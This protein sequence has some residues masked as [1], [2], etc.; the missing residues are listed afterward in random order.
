MEACWLIKSL[1]MI[2]CT[3]FLYN[4]HLCYAEL[5]DA[6]LTLWMGCHCGIGWP[7]RKLPSVP[8]LLSAGGS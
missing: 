2:A 1:E 6:W 4:Q 8:L 3:A 5:S 7:G